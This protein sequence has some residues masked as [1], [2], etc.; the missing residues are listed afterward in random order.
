MTQREDRRRIVLGALIGLPVSVAALWLALRGADLDRVR[1]TLGAATPGWVALA[2]GALALGYVLQGLRWRLIAH[3]AHVPRRRFVEFVISGVAVNNV[4][5]GR[6]GDVLRGRWLGRASGAGFGR[7]VATVVLDRGSDVVALLG[8]LLVSL[9][10]VASDGWTRTIGVATVGLVVVLVAGVLLARWYVKGRDRDRRERGLVRRIVRDALEQLA[11]PLGRR[12]FASA[13]AI[14]L[15]VWG[16][17]ALAATLIARSLGLELGPLEALFVTG[18]VNLG[19]AVPSSPG[20]VGT[21]QWLSI[22]A[23]GPFGIGKDNALAFAILLQAAWY[24]PTTIVGGGALVLRWLGRLRAPP[25]TDP[26]AAPDRPPES[27]LP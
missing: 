18:V 13:L 1:E 23:L 9:P 20:F 14:S 8:F 27:R 26:P 16:L 19:V 15:L 10:F 11:R 4:L 21:Y 2:V 24:V 25:V 6:I 3:A 5:P 22:A 7:G 17:W 12:R